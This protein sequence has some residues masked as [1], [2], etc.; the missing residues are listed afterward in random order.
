MKGDF[1]KTFEEILEL[2]ALDIP[3][4]KR[5]EFKKQVEKIIEFYSVISELPLESVEPTT[6]RFEQKQELREDIPKRFEDVDMMIEN[7]PK[8]IERFCVVPQ[9]LEYRKK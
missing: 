7:F 1:E 9:V 4:E 6:W 2:C 5:E 3:Q 8:T